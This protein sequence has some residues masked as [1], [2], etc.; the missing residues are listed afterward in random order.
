MMALVA[1]VLAL[2]LVLV[3][4]LLLL[5][6]VFLTS[7]VLM[8][9]PW[10]FLHYFNAAYPPLHRLY[11]RLGMEVSVDHIRDLT[12][13]VQRI[14]GRLAHEI[15]PRRTFA[16]CCKFPLGVFKR[17]SLVSEQELYHL[18]HLYILRRVPALTR[19]R[20]VRLQLF[21]RILPEAQRTCRDIQHRNNLADAV[22]GFLGSGH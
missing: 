2:E 21:K 15:I 14:V 20:S 6:K 17:I 4:V 18:A 5:C 16:I 3:V 22:V 9:W 13:K 12:Q 10:L 19:K 11:S 8:W 7:D 1:L